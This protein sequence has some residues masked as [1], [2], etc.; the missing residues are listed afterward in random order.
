MKSIKKRFK[1]QLEQLQTSITAL[2]YLSQD[3]ELLRDITSLTDDLL[4][5]CAALQ[6]YLENCDKKAF[7][8]QVASLDELSTLESLLDLDLISQVEQCLFQHGAITGNSAA[9]D[10]QQQLLNK[11][12]KQY[13][14]VVENT[15]ELIGLAADLA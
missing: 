11:L 5:N 1:A 2:R 4:D 8:T 15:R 9:E 10:I 3:I 12:E 14:L 13:G 7:E 6:R